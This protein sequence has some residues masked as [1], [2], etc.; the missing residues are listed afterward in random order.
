MKEKKK[1]FWAETVPKISAV[2]HQYVQ[3]S[4]DENTEVLKQKDPTHIISGL[5]IE[6]LM[7]VGFQN[8]QE[9]IAFV[10]KYLEYTNHLHNPKY[11]GHQVAVPHPFSGIPDWIHGT[12]NNPSSLYE[13]GPPGGA[14]EG[15]MINWMLDKLGWFKGN[16]YSDFT[17]YPT[18]GSGI[19][20]HGGSI[21]NLTA[22]SAARAAI[23]PEAWTEGTPSDLVVIGPVTSHYSIARAISIMGMGQNS[24]VP[25][26]VDSNE[27]L[28]E[29]D[30]Q[31]VYQSQ[32]KKGKRVMAVVANACATSTGLYDPL[33]EIG[34]F[35]QQ[36]NLW[37]HVD[38]AHGAVALL[39]QKEKEHLKGIE[40]ADSIIWD[41]HKMMRVPALCTAVLFKN[42]F[43]QYNNFTQK[44]SYV[45][46]STE[47][48][49]MDSMPY[50]VECTKSALGTKLFW[51]FALEG[52][53]KLI[54][55]VEHCYQLSSDFYE[56]L[57]QQ[58]DFSTPYAPES[59]ILCFRYEGADT[60]DDFQ[61][62]LRYALIDTGDFYITSCI[63]NHKRYLRVV[64]IHPETQLSHLYALLEK[65]RA[66]AATLT[67]ETNQTL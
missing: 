41:A 20:T 26:A 21:A 16:S 10:D 57:Q 3:N 22:L 53:E 42:Q 48:I 6:Q 31:R 36:H 2:L 28:L 47:V 35:C 49:G 14:L 15:Y 8:E 30:L 45:F 11:M 60:S 25:V 5:N 18:N 61:M 34:A 66:I 32:L 24:Y 29:E 46:H 65:I 1:D 27:V 13:M 56:L 64:L 55:Y 43:H 62:K 33:E 4:Q 44:G 58:E 7:T 39:S 40:M 38:G 63:M 17:K 50:T 9:V 19:L 23:A 54:D 51:T 37:F 12:A 52:E 59:N 67:L